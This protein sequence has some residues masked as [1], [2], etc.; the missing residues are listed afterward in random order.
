M[1]NDQQLTFEFRDELGERATRTESI[2]EWQIPTASEKTQTLRQ[3]VMEQ[4]V[5]ATNMEEAY[6][7][8]KSN[9]GAP[10]VDGMT[11]EELWGWM[12]AHREELKQSLVDGSYEPQ[13]V[14]RDG[15]DE[16]STFNPPSEARS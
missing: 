10:G 11:T 4:V 14:R 13:P 7:R 2:E 16:Q 8:V 6:Q 9:R 5:G 12:N 15:H 1:T 3:G